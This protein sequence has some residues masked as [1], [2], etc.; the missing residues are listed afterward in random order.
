M[1]ELRRQRPVADDRGPAVEQLHVGAA[2]VVII[3]SAVKIMPGLSS[4]R[5]RDA[6]AWTMVQDPDGGL[7]RIE[8]GAECRV[9]ASWVGPMLIETWS[10]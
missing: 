5:C 4:G 7:I 1:L 2:D 8:I 10:P 9:G 6:P 3:G